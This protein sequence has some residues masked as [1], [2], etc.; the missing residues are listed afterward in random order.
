MFIFFFALHNNQGGRKEGRKAEYL[1]FIKSNS[2]IREVKFASG[3]RHCHLCLPGE[4]KRNMNK[5]IIT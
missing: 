3:N 1:Q 5:T 2:R 4:D